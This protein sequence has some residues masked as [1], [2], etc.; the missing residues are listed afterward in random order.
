MNKKKCKV[1]KPL[2]CMYN[3]IMQIDNAPF[4]KRIIN[5]FNKTLVL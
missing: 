5:A 4:F 1:Q 3:N 2:F